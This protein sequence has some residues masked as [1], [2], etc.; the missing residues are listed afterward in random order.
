MA[1]M[2]KLIELV[3]IYPILYDLSHEDYKNVKKKDKAWEQIGVELKES[4]K[5]FCLLF[6]TQKIVQNTCCF[7]NKDCSFNFSCNWSKKYSPFLN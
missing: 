3:K 2:E 5:W 6:G 1:F 4:G 7:N